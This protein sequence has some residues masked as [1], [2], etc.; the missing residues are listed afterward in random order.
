[1]N[2]KLSLWEIFPIGLM[3]FSL[4]FGAG[5]LIFPPALGQAAGTNLI[6][7]ILGFLLTGVGLPLLGI[8]AIARIGNA[9][10]NALANKVH[11]RFS[12]VL[13]TIINLTIGPLFAIPRTGAVAFDVGIRPFLTP[14]GYTMGLFIY[15]ALFFGC[16]Y[17]LA[18]NPNKLV[19]RVGKILTPL[20]LLSLAVLIMQ[21]FFEP[22]GAIGAPLGSYET[23]PFFKGFQE[24]YLTMDLLASV[25]FG[26][27]VIN[28]IKTKG[29]SD[30]AT[31]TKLCI[32]SGLVAAFF[33]AVIYMSLAYM[34]ATSVTLLGYAEN[35]G[36]VLSGVAKHYFG[37]FGNLA[38]GLT[39]TFACLTTSIGLVSS[40]AT[41]FADIFHRQILYER[42]VLYF[43][44]FSFGVSNIGLTKLISFSIPFL[45]G[46]YPIVMVLIILSFFDGLFQSRKEVYQGAIALTTLMSI[47]EGLK[48]AGFSCS[49]I[50]VWCLTYIPLYNFDFGW[51]VPALVGAL[52]GYLYS[53]FS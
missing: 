6:P 31:L 51:I 5:N 44:L 10:S 1:M 50:T 46:I 15:T 53:K 43:T 2:Q 28:S 24:G 26:V 30:A 29:I 47:L 9:N 8:L 42:L 14:D 27:V 12:L 4:F 41:F 19:D 52:G 21:I 39:I 40:C 20:L 22:L 49:S 23:R 36:L 25:V 33:L 37:A 35:G 7:A 11:P 38:L 16:T 45:V 32:L 34:G 48:A 3:L 18:L 17:F 13:M